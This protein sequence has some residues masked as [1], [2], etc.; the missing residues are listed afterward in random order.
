MSHRTR[1]LAEQLK[2]LH[3]LIDS[4]L[5]SQQRVMDERDRRYESERVAQ[6]RHT[7]LALTAAN[8]S[9]LKSEEAQKTY[10]LSIEN[11]RSAQSD[12]MG[13]A[14]GVSGSVAMMIAVAGLVIGAIAGIP[15]VIMLMKGH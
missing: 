3:D 10:N 8:A 2:S 1:K 15:V 12:S 7:A 9:A 14:R 5:E 4:K 11:L 6:E 13:H